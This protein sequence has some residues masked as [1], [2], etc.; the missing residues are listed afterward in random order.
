MKLPGQ[1]EGSFVTL[2]ARG[3][4]GLFARQTLLFAHLTFQFCDR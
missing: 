3:G 4:G 1:E 2:L